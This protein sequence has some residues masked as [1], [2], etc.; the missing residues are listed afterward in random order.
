MTMDHRMTM[1]HFMN[2]MYTEIAR[3]LATERKLASFLILSSVAGIDS[4]I[5]S[6][7][8]NIF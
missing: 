7:Y 6:P 1:S 4:P 3:D 2:G 5:V 8:Q